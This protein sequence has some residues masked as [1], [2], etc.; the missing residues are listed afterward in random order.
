L[1]VKTGT[2]RTDVHSN[3]DNAKIARGIHRKEKGRGRGRR[4]IAGRGRAMVA[5]HHIDLQKEKRKKHNKLK[6][7]QKQGSKKPGQ[8][9]KK[10]LENSTSSRFMRNE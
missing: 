1:K 9:L 5:R 7:S 10:G 4:K 6:Y 2:L 8:G 3:M